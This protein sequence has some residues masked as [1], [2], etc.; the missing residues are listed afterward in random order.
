MFGTL[1]VSER[2]MSASIEILE[3]ARKRR[4]IIKEVPISCAYAHFRFQFNAFEHGLRV[5]L[6]AIKLRLQTG[7]YICRALLSRKKQVRTV[8]PFEE[9]RWAHEDSVRPGER[10]AR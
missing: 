6:S 2:G 10:L 8:D 4:A 1:R 9:A 7:I 5:A 3:Q